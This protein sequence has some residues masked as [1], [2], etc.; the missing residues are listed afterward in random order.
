MGYAIYEAQGR[1]CGYEVQAPCDQE[2]CEVIIDR[3]LYYMCGTSPWG[4]TD[5]CGGFFCDQHAKY[6]EVGRRCPACAEHCFT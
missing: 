3:G 6:T 4:D 1:Q 5:S 2:G